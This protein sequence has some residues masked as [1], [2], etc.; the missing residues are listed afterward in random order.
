MKLRRTQALTDG[1]GDEAQALAF[2][3]G[4]MRE[5]VLARPVAQRRH[6]FPAEEAGLGGRVP[7]LVCL[8]LPLFIS[9][10]ESTGTFRSQA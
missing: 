4:R 8:T 3:R 1:S 2:P 7:A 5:V 6:H 10:L 9:L